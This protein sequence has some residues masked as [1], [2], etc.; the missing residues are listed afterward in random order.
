MTVSSNALA[1]VAFPSEH[2]FRFIFI[3]LVAA[4]GQADLPRAAAELATPPILT[5]LVFHLR[6]RSKR[7]AWTVI[8]GRSYALNAPPEG[9]HATACHM[10]PFRVSRERKKNLSFLPPSSTFFTDHSVWNKTPCQCVQ[11]KQMQT[12]HCS[13]RDWHKKQKCKTRIFHLKIVPRFVNLIEPQES[14]CS[15]S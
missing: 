7:V 6:I 3:L 15:D 4:L 5:S 8:P 11:K 13:S 9:S 10:W 2:P 12:T 14:Y 1:K